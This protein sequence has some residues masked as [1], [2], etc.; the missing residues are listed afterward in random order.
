LPTPV[1]TD[2]VL[3]RFEDAADGEAAE[4][5]R[6]SADEQR[7]EQHQHARDGVARRDV[8]ELRGGTLRV[9]EEVESGV[10]TDSHTPW[11]DHVVLGRV[12]LA[13]GVGTLMPVARER[14]AVPEDASLDDFLDAGDD[15]GESPVAT[16][17]E[18]TDDDGE[19]D[20]VATAGETRG[21]AAG[22]GGDDAA[23]EGGDGD[24]GEGGDG[25]AGEGGDGDAAG[26]EASDHDPPSTADVEPAV[27][28]YTWA[29]A[30]GVCATCG[31][32]VDRRWRADDD[33][34]CAACKEW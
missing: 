30:G 18:A 32:T 1:G 2:G 31:E 9:R 24:A 20:D 7:A 12:R 29:A 28:T 3:Q 5:D 26:T 11:F 14:P 34:V 4:R 21:D 22:E 17:P 16:E 13:V 23:G 8:G 15:D 25:D 6:C 19:A 33:L 10:V 27:S